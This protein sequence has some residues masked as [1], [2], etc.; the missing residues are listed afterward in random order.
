MKTGCNYSEKK[1]RVV[2]R[3]VISRR[4]KKMYDGNKKERQPGGKD[5]VVRKRDV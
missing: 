4:S 5:A 2:K 3:V 1:N